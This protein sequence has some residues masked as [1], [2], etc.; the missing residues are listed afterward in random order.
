MKIDKEFIDKLVNIVENGGITAF[1]FMRALY[2][3]EIPIINRPGEGMIFV[4]DSL[5]FLIGADTNHKVIKS[6]IKEIREIPLYNAPGLKQYTYEEIKNVIEQIEN[7]I[8]LY[9]GN[10]LS[11]AKSK[12]L[13][14]NITMEDTDEQ[15]E[16]NI[17]ESHNFHDEIRKIIKSYYLKEYYTEAVFEAAKTYN[18]LVKE[19]S[20]M[21]LGET[22][23]MF[24]AWDLKTGTLKVNKCET[25]TE[26]NVQNGLC[27]LSA[28]LM[29][30][31]RNPNAHEPAHLWPT[32][33]ED[34]LDILAF[35]SFLLRQLDKAVYSK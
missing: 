24:Q 28:G 4:N 17:F 25:E 29:L 13:V 1:A 2:R 10:N 19:K 16:T 27:H 14:S 22:K 31:I 32:S 23:L 21:E 26:M 12:P 9:E 3:A 8:D 33:K 11:G 5:N 6:I 15:F 34:C 20:Q 7:L 30:A 35:T 18:K